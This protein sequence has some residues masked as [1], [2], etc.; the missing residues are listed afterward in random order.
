MK[1]RGRT[2][3]KGISVADEN[4]LVVYKMKAYLNIMAARAEGKAHG[5]DGNRKN[6]CKHRNDAVRLLQEGRIA[7]LPVPQEIHDDVQNFA[8]L[9]QSDEGVRASLVSSFHSLYPQLNVTPETLDELAS[10]I[11]D[12]F[13]LRE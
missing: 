9:L 13:P 7:Q 1:F 4:V 3:A 5:S 11:R 6:A 8:N 2:Q 12:K 10:I